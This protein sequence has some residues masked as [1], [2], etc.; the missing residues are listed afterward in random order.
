MNHDICVFAMRG[1]PFG[2]QHLDNILTGL[3]QAQSVFVMIGSAN[4]PINF[5]NPFTAAEVMQM[6]RGSLTELQNDRVYLIPVEDQDS[7]LKWVAEVQRLVRREASHLSLTE[8][9]IT[10]IGHSKDDSSFY[11]KMFPHW[12]SINTPLFGNGMSATDIR[13][14]LYEADS[15]DSALVMDLHLPKGTGVFLRQWINSPEF[16]RMKEEYEFNKAEAAK[17][18]AHPYHGPGIA[19]HPTADLC[20]FQAGGVV[21]VR[22]NGKPGEGLWALPGGH[23]DPFERCEDCAV[24]EFLQETLALEL[25]P[26]LEKSDIQSA[27][28][29]MKLCDNP[30]RS[31]RFRTISMAYGGILPGVRRIE[32]KGGDDARE[33]RFWNLDE[34]T[35]DMMF[36]DHFL[37]IQHFANKLDIR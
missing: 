13:N 3:D 11:L 2:F 4:E 20:L 12:G 30:W 35:R 37:I 33:A 22:R 1:R 26:H 36:E 9:R 14:T 34:I 6:I 28:R 32:V 5:R 31:T 8:P 27:I 15:P 17:F 23:V 25:N 16:E 10:L 29:E 24:R 7:D 19:F 21:L 18:P